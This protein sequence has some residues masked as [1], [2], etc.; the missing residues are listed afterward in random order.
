MIGQLDR[1]HTERARREC[2]G[3]HLFYDVFRLLHVS[4]LLP[5]QGHHYLLSEQT[6]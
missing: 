1:D 2:A 5:L 4:F 6:R 3:Q